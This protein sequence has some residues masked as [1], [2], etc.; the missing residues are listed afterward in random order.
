MESFVK[1]TGDELLFDCAASCHILLSNEV[2]FME[3][4]QT[5]SVPGCAYPSML[6][7]PTLLQAHFLTIPHSPSSAIS[8]PLISFIVFSRSCFLFSYRLLE[9][10]W[11]RELTKE[12]CILLVPCFQHITHKI[13]TI[14]N[15]P[16]KSYFGHCLIYIILAKPRGPFHRRLLSYSNL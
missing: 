14:R 1:D 2:N 8:L 12:L 16:S 13:T 11:K 7:R 9:R 3:I 15:N 4:V 10:Q 6:V 5:L